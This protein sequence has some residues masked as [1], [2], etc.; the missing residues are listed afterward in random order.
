MI[1][2]KETGEI[3]ETTRGR[4]KVLNG[5]ASVQNKE[6]LTF[7]SEESEPKKSKVKDEKMRKHNNPSN[8]YQWTNY[9]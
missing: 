2:K 1:K 6:K 3:K 9:N 7:G 5:K 4:L 8:P